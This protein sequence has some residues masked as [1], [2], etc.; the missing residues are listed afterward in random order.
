LAVDLADV[1]A[2]KTPKPIKDLLPSLNFIKDKK[3]YGLSLRQGVRKIS[4]KDY[5]TIVSS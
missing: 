4:E 5:N 2:W 1:E 3:N